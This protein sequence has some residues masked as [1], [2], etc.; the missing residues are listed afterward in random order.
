ML[1]NVIP[2]DWAGNVVPHDHAN[3]AP[4]KLIIRR[5]SRSNHVVRDKNRGCDRLSSAL[6]KFND[7]TKHLSCDSLTCIVGAG[8]DPAA[9]A[10]SAHW[11]GA[12]TITVTN[13]RSLQDPTNPYKIG[14]VPLPDNDCHGAIWGKI[15]K[16]QSN[17]LISKSEWLVA[18]AGVE[19]I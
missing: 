5:V 8:A 9:W 16:G 18:L 12:V 1:V 17:K 19:I 2:V 13:F 14:M 7:P 10:P 3:F 4:E 11:D 15:T 6:Y